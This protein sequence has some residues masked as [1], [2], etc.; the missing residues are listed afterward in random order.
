MVKP[1]NLKRMTRVYNVYFLWDHSQ[2]YRPLSDKAAPFDSKKNLFKDKTNRF[3][4]RCCRNTRSARS[5]RPSATSYLSPSL[6]LSHA[7]VSSRECFEKIRIS[8]ILSQ[9]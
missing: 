8:A 4:S 7:R 9:T 6:S 1:F 5:P 2:F 3:R